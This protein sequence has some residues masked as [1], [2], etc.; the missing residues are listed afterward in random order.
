MITF[1]KATKKFG[2]IIALDD[3]SFSIDKGEFVFLTGHSGAGKTTV[4]RLI[5]GEY[6]PT[7][8]EIK[9]SSEI[10]NKIPKRKLYLWRRKIGVVFQDYR[11]LDDRTI[12]ENVSLPLEFTKTSNLEI[13][14]KTQKVLELTGLK[15]RANLFPAQLAGGEL[16]RACLARAVITDPEIILAD[17][18]TG[19]L[20][21]TTAEGMINLFKEINEKGTTVLMATHNK[22]IV[23]SAKARVIELQKG[24]VVRDV[25]EGK[26][27]A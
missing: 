12:W 7:S 21:P 16:Q 15:E 18:P 3:V 20:D 24:K 9:V 27:H 6:L 1:D 5:L 8:G 14:E 23:D 11:L 17:E 2:G 10:V 25:K 4:I 26:Y 22:D 19:N 13:K